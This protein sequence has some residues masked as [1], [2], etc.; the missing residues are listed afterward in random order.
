ME[1][2]FSSRFDARKPVR[3][4]TEEKLHIR[5]PDSDFSS[6]QFLLDYFKK[7]TCQ[8]LIKSKFLINDINLASF[9]VLNLNRWKKRK[10][11]N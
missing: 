9:K 6:I 2:K 7:K 10:K 8:R 5:K 11:Q 3:N 4:F 1:I